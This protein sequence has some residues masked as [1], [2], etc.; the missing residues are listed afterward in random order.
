ML[1]PASLRPAAALRFPDH[2]TESASSLSL[3]APGRG[4]TVHAVRNG[5]QSTAV[6]VRGAWR[7]QRRTQI[8][9]SNVGI[10]EVP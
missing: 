3:N 4:T 1:S 5:S 10:S 8:D 9:A 2:C 7:Q 6:Q